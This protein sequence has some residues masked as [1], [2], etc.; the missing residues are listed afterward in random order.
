MGA[1]YLDWAFCSSPC[2]SEV[3]DKSLLH[4]YIQSF[5]FFLFKKWRQVNVFS[6]VWMLTH[7]KGRGE[8]NRRSLD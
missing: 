2:H 7:H 6:D 4:T 1:E 8:K 3:V 5:I